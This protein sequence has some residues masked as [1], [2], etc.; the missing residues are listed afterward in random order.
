MIP[1]TKPFLPPQEEYN[2]YL[3]GIWQRNWLT[4]MGPLA[5]NLEMQLKDFLNVKH[6]LFV[7]NGTLAL[8]LA[9][10]SLDLRGEIITTPF[11]FVATTSSIVWEGCK[12]IF[13]DIDI[14]SLNIDAN[15]I[16][17]AITPSTTAILA[18]HVYGN[19]CDVIAIDRI[20][21]K[22]NL[23]VIYDGAHAFGVTIMGKSIFE[24]GDISICS[25]HATKLY[26][27]I[28]GGLVIT[29]SAELLKR[30]AYMRN[31]GF[32]G[33]ESFSELGINCKNSE[34]HAAMGL[35]NLKYIE[36]I[37][38]NRKR[39]VERYTNNLKSFKATRPIWFNGSF[40]NYAYYPIIIESEKLL[41]KV[42][43]I[44]DGNEI[45]T[46][47][48]FYPSLSK[49]L[50]YVEAKEM[51]IT[52]DISKRV[53]CLPLYPDLTDEEVDLICRLMLRIQN[54]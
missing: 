27:S 49:V 47:R 21:K 11:S 36:Y 12:P 51:P 39:I 34:F 10:K 54:N 7:T 18:T 22:Y 43:E 41:L 13:V 32:N 16:E 4:N 2:K 5:S 37:Y 15:K 29:K 19:P 1:V 8:Q 48:Y 46:R 23:K 6:L 14:N 38:Q 45:F 35:V 25:L 33:P 53:L 9:I 20:A 44:L 17:A 50:P 52:E 42:V 40:D 26:H 28:E 31:F 24:Y 3:N 30:I